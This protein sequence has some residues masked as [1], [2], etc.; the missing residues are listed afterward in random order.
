M[1]FRIL[2]NSDPER[3]RAGGQPHP[4]SAPA[5]WRCYDPC[6]AAL[7][8][9]LALALL[10][11]LLPLLLLVALLVKLTSPGPVIYRQARLG[12]GGRPFLV[13]KFR[14]VRQGAEWRPGLR[15]S[16]PSDPRVTP[17]GRFL[18]RTHLDG[19]PQLWNVLRGDMSLVGPRPERPEFVPALERALPGYRERLGVRPGVTGLAQVQLPP[20]TDLDSVR[21]KLA[22]DLHYVRQRGPW[23]DLRLLL[24]APLHAAGAPPRWLRSIFRLPGNGLGGE[25]GANPPGPGPPPLAGE[26][27]PA[28]LPLASH[29]N[30]VLWRPSLG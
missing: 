27:G 22:Y 12:R 26:R 16:T 5:P 19:L 13:Y 8:F 10:L 29:S 30:R 14:T 21:R 15:W 18:R 2:G 23:L 1:T 11:L 7:D 25:G 17:V 9:A 28:Q 6:K 20:D 3:G 4:A 24:C